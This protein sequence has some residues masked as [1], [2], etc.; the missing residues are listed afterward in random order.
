MFYLIQLAFQSYS[1]ELSTLYLVSQHYFWQLFVTCFSFSK[2]HSHCFL[3]EKNS[4]FSKAHSSNLLVVPAL[5]Y[6]VTLRLL[7]V[8]YR[9][10]AWLPSKIGPLLPFLAH[11]KRRLLPQSVRSLVWYSQVSLA[12][13]GS[14]ISYSQFNSSLET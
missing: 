4:P 9:Y 5:L 13:V 1:Q 7:V 12:A 8:V 10:S 11:L 3:R 6:F 2:C 14:G